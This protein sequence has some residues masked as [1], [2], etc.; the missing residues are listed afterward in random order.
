MRYKRFNLQLFAE[1]GGEGGAEG[2]VQGTQTTEGTE[3]TEADKAAQAAAEHAE[4]WNNL[5]KGEYKK[6]FNDAIKR[7]LDRRFAHQAELEAELEGN[8]KLMAFLADRYALDSSDADGLM[9]ALQNDDA[10][11]E[12]EAVKR[13]LT[14]DQYKEVKRLEFENDLFRQQQEA[15]EA[16]RAADETYTRWV[17]E[18]EALKTIYPNFDIE[19][20]LNLSPDFGR[21]LQSGVSVQAAYQA[22]HMDEVLGGAM[23]YTAQNVAEKVTNNVLARGLRPIEN[24]IGATSQPVKQTVDPSKLTLDQMKDYARRAAR[25]ETITFK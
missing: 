25:G 15:E 12:S 1:G 6:D 4:N 22:T 18:A 20:E 7:N 24:G 19:E 3:Q 13:G 10:L 14:V 5:I 23:A 8:R 2:S 11:F 17:Q 16:R 21:L 9:E